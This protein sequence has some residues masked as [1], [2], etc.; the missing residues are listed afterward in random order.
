MRG[1]DGGRDLGRANRP[2][3][4]ETKREKMRDSKAREERVQWIVEKVHVKIG[5]SE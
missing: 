4:G 1:S 3:K 5:D 2:E